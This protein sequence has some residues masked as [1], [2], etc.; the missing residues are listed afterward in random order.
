MTR[1]FLAAAVVASLSLVAC[2]PQQSSTPDPDTAG[3]GDAAAATKTVT[4]NVKGMT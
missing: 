1:L 4:V 3:G 2:T